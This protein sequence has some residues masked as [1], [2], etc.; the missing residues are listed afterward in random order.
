[1]NQLATKW[2]KAQKSYEAKTADP[3]S[4]LALNISF[5]L[6]IA[7]TLRALTYLGPGTKILDLAAGNGFYAGKPQEETGYVY[8]NQDQDVTKCDI[9]E[10]HEMNGKFVRCD[11]HN[12]SFGNEIFDAVTCVFSLDHFLSP[13]TVFKEAKRVLR[14]GGKFFVAQAVFHYGMD[15]IESDHHHHI[16]DFSLTSIGNL[17]FKAGFSDALPITQ[18]GFEGMMF[19]AGEKPNGVGE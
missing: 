4:N 13:V 5:A 17:Y 8:L 1:M 3:D 6:K 18:M 19:F 11:V 16:Y 2:E 9:L 7:E 15:P 10:P 14:P 12:L